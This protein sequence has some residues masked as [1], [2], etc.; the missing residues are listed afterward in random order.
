MQDKNS[1]FWSDEY[2]DREDAENINRETQSKNKA[3]K[4]WIGVLIVIFTFLIVMLIT[5]FI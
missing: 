2:H 5:H 4:P 1:Q 3:S